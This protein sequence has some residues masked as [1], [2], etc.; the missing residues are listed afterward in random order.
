M[1]ES[2][3]KLNYNEIKRLQGILDHPHPIHGKGN[4]P[5]IEVEPRRLIQV[6]ILILTIL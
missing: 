6:K 3:E 4:F 2:S 1:K 5:T